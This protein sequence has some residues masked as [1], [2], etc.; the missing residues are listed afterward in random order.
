MKKQ[1]EAYRGTPGRASRISSPA[2]T[3]CAK[4]SH[5]L[6]LYIFHLWDGSSNIMLLAGDP[7]M[8]ERQSID[9]ES[10]DTGRMDQWYK[11]EDEE[12]V[13]GSSGNSLDPKSSRVSTMACQS[14]PRLLIKVAVMFIPPL[15]RRLLMED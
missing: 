12:L 10:V 1:R 6:C 14:T 2:P 7:K 5:G 11:L 13:Y 9:E 15:F 3:N 4:T 8:R